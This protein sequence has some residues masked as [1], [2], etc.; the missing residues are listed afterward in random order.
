VTGPLDQ[1]DDE[2]QYS[3]VF[4]FT[5]CQSNGGPYDDDAFVAGVQFGRIDQALESAGPAVDRM[6][7]TAYTSLTKQLELCG[8]A[9]GFPV[10]TAEQVEETDDHPAMPEWSFFTFAQA[11]EG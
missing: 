3:L 11:G 4:P 8:M 2:T 7:F 9:R 6:R 10:I 1:P 5:V